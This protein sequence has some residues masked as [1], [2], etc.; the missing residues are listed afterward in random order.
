MSK[1][2]VNKMQEEIDLQA[3]KSFRPMKRRF[4]R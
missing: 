2:A 4:R 3:G 1:M